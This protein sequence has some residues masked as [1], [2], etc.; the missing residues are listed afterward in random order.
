MF[1]DSTKIMLR[2]LSTIIAAAYI[3]AISTVSCSRAAPT[4]EGEPGLSIAVSILPQAYFAQRIAGDRARVLTLVGPGASPHSYE[5]SPR[6]LADLSRASVW[7]ITGIEFENALLPKI[8]S[9][10]PTLAIVDAVKDAEFRLMEAHD[11]EEEADELHD[12][13]T[14]EAQ[15]QELDHDE[16]SAMDPHTWLGPQGA[17]TQAAAIRDALTAIDPDGAKVYSDNYEVFAREVDGLFAR[18][19][20]ELAPLRG[21][22]VFVYHPAFGYF[23][24]AF[25]IKQ[26]AVETGGKEPTPKQLA[27]LVERA[28]ADGARVLFVQKQFPSASAR[29]VADAIGGVVVE[30]DDLAED[31][32]RNLERMAAALRKAIR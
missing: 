32:A 9:L 30:M 13:E 25:G 4:P 28:S 29:A 14:D 16:E 15:G 24:D 18:L 31:W 5:L 6:Q 21:A 11:H 23:L 3:L 19:T 8:S 7:F 1:A 20:L 27:D 10:Y 12:G 26:E 2:A 17:K 22:T